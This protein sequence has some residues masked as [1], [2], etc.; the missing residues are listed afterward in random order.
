MPLQTTPMPSGGLYFPHIGQIPPEGKFS[1]AGKQ[2]IFQLPGRYV[3][4]CLRYG[5][6]ETVDPSFADGSKAGLLV[7][8]MLASAA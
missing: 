8:S 5:G 1:P 4:V 7:K 6:K 2:V 3:L